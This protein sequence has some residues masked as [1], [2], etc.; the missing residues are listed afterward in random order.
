MRIVVRKTISK[1]KH[2]Y[3]T[4]LTSGGTKKLLAYLNERLA[5]GEALGPDSPVIAPD[6]KYKTYRGRNNEK[7]FLPTQRLLK[8]IRRT[9]RPRFL[10]RPYVFRAFFDTQL[11]IAESRGKI[12]HD[13][14]V[15]FMG[16]VG[17]IEAKYTTNKSILPEALVTEMKEAF[18]RCEEFLDLEVKEEDPLLKQKEQ[19]RQEIDKATPER[20]QEILRVLG[21][22]NS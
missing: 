1:A 9:L 11:L 19:L 7:G 15:F 10:W 20:V 3:F 2:Q 6:S 16:H 5:R 8:D 21:V 14:R 4:L 22:C 18:K 17:S 13:F 12:A